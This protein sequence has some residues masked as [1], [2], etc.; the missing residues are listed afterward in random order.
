LLS[1]SYADKGRD[2]I[3]GSKY[4][5]FSGGIKEFDVSNNFD[6]S[7][8]VNSP[9]SSHSYFLSQFVKCSYDSS[10]NIKLFVSNKNNTDSLLKW[11]FSGT[12]GI[13]QIKWITNNLLYIVAWDYQNG[14]D[15]IIFDSENKFVVYHMCYHFFK[16]TNENCELLPACLK[17]QLLNKKS[18]PKKGN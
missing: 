5:G 11:H 10:V 3:D 13:G 1:I 7:V 16:K 15:E 14:A 8:F 12:A 6:K 18:L 2:P 17:M 4:S 9:D